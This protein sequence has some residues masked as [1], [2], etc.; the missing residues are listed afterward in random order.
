MG[1]WRRQV[2]NWACEGRIYADLSAVECQIDS[3]SRRSNDPIKYSTVFSL[4]DV[5]KFT[6]DKEKEIDQIQDE[7]DAHNHVTEIEFHTPEL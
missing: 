3:Y 4:T 6:K 5:E 7:I 1:F 2:V